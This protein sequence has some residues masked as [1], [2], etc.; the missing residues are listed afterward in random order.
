VETVAAILKALATMPD[1]RN[2]I[3]E[4]RWFQIL[5]IECEIALAVIL[6][7]DIVPKISWLVTTILFTIFSIVSLTKVSAVLIHVVVGVVPLK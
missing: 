3:F 6:L 5:L 7:F 4:A 2:S 1:F